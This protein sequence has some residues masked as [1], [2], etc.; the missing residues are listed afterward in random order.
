M[1][2]C[3][4]LHMLQVARRRHQ[5][6]GVG[7]HGFVKDCGDVVI[8]VEQP[9]D[10]G[11]IVEPQQHRPPVVRTVLVMEAGLRCS[12]V[13]ERHVVQ[14]AVEASR[15]LGDAPAPCHR[16]SNPGREVHRLA[17]GIGEDHPVQRTKLPRQ[18][19]GCAFL[20]GV[21]ERGQRT[22]AQGTSAGL[23]HLRVGMAEDRS[24]KSHG[25]VHIADAV[26]PKEIGSSASNDLQLA[27]GNGW[28]SSGTA[29]NAIDET[30]HQSPEMLK[31][32]WLQPNNR[33]SG[34]APASSWDRSSG[35]ARPASKVTGAA[36]RHACTHESFSI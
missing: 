29:G 6:A 15:H 24:A 30:W 23:D 8:V 7:Q 22:V 11:E 27:S 4:G 32:A 20:A 28:Q 34:I 10:I 26:I 18:G 12:D 33:S 31:Q 1:P 21:A 14:P 3:R 13:A 5:A 25:G 9:L 35:T 2:P 36:Q 17:A 19:L 16:A